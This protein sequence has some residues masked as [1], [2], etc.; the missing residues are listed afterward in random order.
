MCV[1]VKVQKIL[2][3]RL[4]C[5]NCHKSLFVTDEVN[6][7]VICSCCGHVLSENTEFRGTER[8]LVDSPLDTT[9]TGPGISP[10]M[11]DM[12]L[13]TV[14]GTKNKDSLGNPLAAK[15]AH[16]FKRLRKWDNRSRIEGAASNENLRLAL[17]ELD[18]VKAKLGLS[19]TIIERASIFYRKAVDR[20]LIRGRTVKGMAAACLYA[21]CRDLE[22]NRTL[23]EIS[24]EFDIG[25][26]EISRAYR[27]LYR[28]LGFTVIIADP[29][30]SIRKIGS[31][32]KLSES[33]IRKAI[34]I[35]HVA[36]DAGV[37]SGKH[38]ETVAAT[39]IYAACVLTGELKSQ[40]T[41]ANIAGTSSVSIRNRINE[42][43]MELDLFS[44]IT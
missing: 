42:F 6:G 8:K 25:R 10:K 44:T 41:I 29:V 38:P 12:G 11:Y 1:L 20:K 3:D 23:T 37:T 15:S 27:I 9:R 28:E 19:N 33:S 24:K 7:E 40:E 34:H 2:N 35:F 17:M 21:S 18:K 39:V 22:H 4:T 26:K 30:K 14:I 36:Q 5:S 32:L 43:K 13:S 16:T 31:R